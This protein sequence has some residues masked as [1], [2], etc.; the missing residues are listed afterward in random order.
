M[1][2]EHV[3]RLHYEFKLVEVLWSSTSIFFVERFFLMGTMLRKLFHNFNRIIKT[4]FCQCSR[5]F[6]GL[7][8]FQ[9]EESR[10]K[11]SRSGSPRWTDEN[12]DK[13]QDLERLDRL[14]EGSEKTWIWVKPPLIR[15]SAINWKWEQLSIAI[16]QCA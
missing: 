11:I 14:I 13:V 12:V 10:L 2:G 7:K 9:K 6:G 1:T 16:Q 8:H 3:I 5:T 4:V 15:F